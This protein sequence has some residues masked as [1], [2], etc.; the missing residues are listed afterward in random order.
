MGK[1]IEKCY[2]CGEKNECAEGCGCSK[3]IFPS[4]YSEWA[5]GNPAIYKFYLKSNIPFYELLFEKA[6]EFENRLF[7]GWRK[8][9]LSVLKEI[10][11]NMGDWTTDG[12]E[13]DLGEEPQIKQ[14]FKKR[15]LYYEF[16]PKPTDNHNGPHHC[17]ICGTSLKIRTIIECSKL[18]LAVLIGKT[19]NRNFRF[20]EEM[21]KDM[22]KN[23]TIIIRKDFTLNLRS[24]KKQKAA[25]LEKAKTKTQQKAINN[26]INR[27]KDLNRQDHPLPVVLT[28][29]NNLR[30]AEKLGFK[31]DFVRKS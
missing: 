12:V 18:K 24:I 10:D 1:R 19:C 2:L 21:Y 25:L 4:K 26:I 5:E 16:R 22:K 15:D 30:R 31:I 13:Y 27:M 11:T 9:Q 6:K 23:I 29:L 17:Q 20:A 28:L 3:C 7:L 14:D 8:E